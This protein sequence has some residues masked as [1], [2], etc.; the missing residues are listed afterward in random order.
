MSTNKREKEDNGDRE[1]SRLERALEIGLE[2][3]FP[4]SDSVAV[5]QPRRFDEQA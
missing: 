4:A 2:D 3:T 5:I 1:F